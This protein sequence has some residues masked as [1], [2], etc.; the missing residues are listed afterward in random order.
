MLILARHIF[1]K[2]PGLI[3]LRLK[4]GGRNCKLKPAAY[5]AKAG[6]NKVFNF[7]WFPVWKIRFWILVFRSLIL[8]KAKP[9]YFA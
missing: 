9:F 7:Y 6:Q 3:N 2:I 1:F 8:L 4:L 5:L